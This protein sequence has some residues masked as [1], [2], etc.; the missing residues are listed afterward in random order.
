MQIP[1]STALC[2]AAAAGKKAA[3]HWLLERGADVNRKTRT[4]QS[5]Y[6]PL[7]AAVTH[8]ARLAT[9]QKATRRNATD[10]MLYSRGPAIIFKTVI[11][12]RRHARIVRSDQSP[13][14]RRSEP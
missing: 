4:H 5:S 6:T 13:A 14:R 7:Q 11:I 3:V 2:A 9:D 10:A 12:R 1:E 8:G